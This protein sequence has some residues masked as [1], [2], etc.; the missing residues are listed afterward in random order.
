MVRAA[1]SCTSKYNP[2]VKRKS[3]IYPRVTGL[4]AALS[5]YSR[6]RKEAALEL[7]AKFYHS[8]A[9]SMMCE[10]LLLCGKIPCHMKNL[11]AA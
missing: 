7:L 6:R 1:L 2:Y 8:K 10:R 3:E 9:N 11:Y 4:R 5:K